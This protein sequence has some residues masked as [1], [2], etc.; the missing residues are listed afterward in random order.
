[1][2]ETG[3][4]ELIPIDKIRLLN[5]T[6][7]IMWETLILNKLYQKYNC[8]DEDEQNQLKKSKN[9]QN[10]YNILVDEVVVI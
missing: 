6:Y 7:P 10:E 4:S 3:F 2:V 1:M 5:R 9:I 8:F